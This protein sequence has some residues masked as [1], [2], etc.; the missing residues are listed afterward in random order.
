M[1]T[2]ILFVNGRGQTALSGQLKDTVTS[3]WYSNVI[4]R[5]NA[6]GTMASC[7]DAIVPLVFLKDNTSQC[8]SDAV[9]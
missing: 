9:S 2:Y 5:R 6:F 1:D 4:L 8:L 7:H 3:A